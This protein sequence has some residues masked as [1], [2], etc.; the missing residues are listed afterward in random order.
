MSD[1]LERQTATLA[2]LLVAGEFRAAERTLDAVRELAWHRRA[3]EVRA[4]RHAGPG[5]L[6]A[7]FGRPVLR[8]K[9]RTHAIAAGEASDL[10]SAGR[11]G[12]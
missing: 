7:S 5:P 11:L 9:P 10:I 2:A 6:R 3:R 4:R 1:H 8:R 12:A